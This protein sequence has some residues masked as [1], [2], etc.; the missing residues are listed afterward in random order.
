M[1]NQDIFVGTGSNPVGRWDYGPWIIPPMI[2]ANPNLPALS[3]VPEAFFDTIVT[4]GTAYPYVTLQRKAY[5]F[6]VLNGCN[7]RILNLHFFYADPNAL[8]EVKMVAAAPDNVHPDWPRDGR[9][10]GVPDANTAGPSWYQIGNEGG[11][12]PRVA[13]VAPQPVDFD[14][15]RRSATFGSVTSK[16][17]FLAPAERADVIVDFSSCPPGSTLILYNDAPAPV[18]LFDPRYDLYT[19]C[20]DQTAI[21]G[22][23]T[24]PAGFGPNTRTVMQVRIDPNAPA[25]PFDLA[26]LQAALPVAYGAV[27]PPPV[28]PQPEYDA[29]FGTVTAANTYARLMDESLNLTG[30]TQGVAKVVTALPGVGYMTPPTVVFMGGGG[31]GARATATL[32]GV[33]GVTVATGGTGYTTKPT[34][35]FTPAAGGGGTG[36]TAMATISG[37]KVTAITMITPG[38]NYLLPPL[39]TITGGGGTGATATAMTTLGSVGSINVTSPGAGYKQAPLVF[40]TGGGGMGAVADALLVGAEPIRI[41]NIVEGMEPWYGRMNA[42]LG[43]TPTPL[44]P[45]VPAPVFPGMSNYIDPPS[46]YITDGFIQLWRLSHIGVDTHVIHF[47][48]VNVQVINRVDI[49][50]VMKPPDENELGW[51][52][53]IR[54][55]PLEDIIMAVRPSTPTMPWPLP[56]SKRLLDPSTMAGSTMSFSPIP[57]PPGVAVAAQVSNVMTDYGWEYVWH[58]HLLGHEENDMMRPLIM[59]FPPW[60]NNTA[61]SGLAATLSTGVNPLSVALRWTDRTPNEQGFVIQRATNTNFT[62]NLKLMFAPANATTYPDTT[63][64][65]RTTYYYRIYAWKNGGQSGNSN[66]LTVT[67]PTG[68]PP[69]GTAA[70]LAVSGVIGRNTVTVTW[71][72]LA[73][74]ASNV[75]L[76]VTSLGV[77]GPWTT[78]TLPAGTTTYTRTGMTPNTN[79]WF[80]VA[81]TNAGGTSAYIPVPALNV[82]TAP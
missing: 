57:P 10:G 58:C 70:N 76:Q 2:P 60:A 67:T 44:L 40:L 27:Q 25:V 74:N 49:T 66:T 4:N 69:N 47:H 23:P 13:I 56:N 8:T 50:S 46:D 72:N 63:V 16:A 39:V 61:P 71:Q 30:K 24:I 17:L 38:S 79:Y 51:K 41:K 48:H 5:R 12:L 22:A 1:P 26:R 18:P 54:A 32:N 36:A 55:N 42:L 45:T 68:P 15:D 53:S 64:A 6:R 33:T 29:A 9:D 31:T 34:V 59:A 20:P 7:D 28:V 82:R 75:L 14:Y 3:T 81:E 78:V 35:T 37:G 80:R 21:G 77:N 65:G 43:T 11:F 62:T 19:G 52:E 73:T